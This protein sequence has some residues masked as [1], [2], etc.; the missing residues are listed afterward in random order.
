MKI[1]SKS[2]SD[3]L[4]RHRNILKILIL[5]KI[6]ARDKEENEKRWGWGWGEDY[7]YCIYYSETGRKLYCPERLLT[8]PAR[9]AG[10]TLLKM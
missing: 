9:P 3:V 2:N 8:M 6:K 10:Q 1:L 5:H 4:Y 7:I